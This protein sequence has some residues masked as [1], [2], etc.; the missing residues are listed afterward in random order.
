M[1]NNKIQLCVAKNDYESGDI[2]ISEVDL[3]GFK[4][5]NTQVD[6]KQ[7]AMKMIW[8]GDHCCVLQVIGGKSFLMIGPGV[9]RNVEMKHDCV[10]STEIDGMRVLTNNSNKLLRMIP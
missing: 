7:E 4:I 10:I 3:K 8:C 9:S 5:A 2:Q 1:G 6:G